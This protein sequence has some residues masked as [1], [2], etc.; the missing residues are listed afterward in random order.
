MAELVTGRGKLVVEESLSSSD[1][2]DNNEILEKVYHTDARVTAM[3][4]QIADISHSM[5]RIETLLLNKQETSPLAWFGVIFSVL[6]LCG[7]LLAAMVTY[8]SMSTEPLRDKMLEHEK[9]VSEFSDFKHQ[10]HYEMGMLHEWKRATDER[11]ED[12][13]QS[14]EKVDMHG[15]RRFNSERQ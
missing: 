5:G 12:V 14:V 11:I 6:T 13:K 4:A 10:T 2:K 1:M 9:Y 3:E 7:G 15:S 8:F